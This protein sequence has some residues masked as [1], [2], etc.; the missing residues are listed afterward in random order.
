M[1]LVYT[2]E[3]TTECNIVKGHLTKGLNMS[4]YFFNSQQS[5]KILGG[6]WGSIIIQ[7]DDLLV[8]ATLSQEFDVQTEII[9]V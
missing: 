2:L 9:F 3:E 6:V 5:V 1:T 4:T 8:S 7:I